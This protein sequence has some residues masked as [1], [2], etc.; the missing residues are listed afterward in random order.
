MIKMLKPLNLVVN[1]PFIK[2][3][4]W[5]YN[6]WTILTDSS[7]ETEAGS[8][9]RGLSVD[10]KGLDH[11]SSRSYLQELQSEGNFKCTGHNRG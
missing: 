9:V 7:A 4:T 3:F 5:L 11:Y 1:H 6:E 2:N 8:F 10:S